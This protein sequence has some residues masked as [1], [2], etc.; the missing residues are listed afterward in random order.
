MKIIYLFILLVVVGVFLWL[1][2]C[3]DRKVEKVTGKE[4]IREGDEIL[5]T[6]ATRSAQAFF[7][8]RLKRDGTLEYTLVQLPAKDTTKIIGKF[9]IAD[10][11][12]NDARFFPRLYG[13]DEKGDTLFNYFIQ[14]V[15]PYN[16]TVD[17]YDQLI[18]SPNSIFDTIVYKF[19]RIKQ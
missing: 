3:V 8:F 19:Y 11:R 15:T 16:S 2:Q 5:G 18:L 12:G 6:W 14:R 4:V 1:R 17:K 13:F 9:S 10:A 7:Q